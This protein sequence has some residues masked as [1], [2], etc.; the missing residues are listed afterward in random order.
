MRW[1]A[2]C[3]ALALCASRIAAGAPAASPPPR[4]ERMLLHE[5]WTLQSSCKLNGAGGEKIA[6]VGFSTAGWHRT[7]VPS[8]VVAALVSDKTF[9]DPYFAVNLRSLP[10]MN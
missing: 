1:F 2:K 8:T 9:P 7:T 3:S 10:G 5:N 6:A 4:P